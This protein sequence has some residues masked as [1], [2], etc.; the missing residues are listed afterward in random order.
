MVELIVAV[1]VFI[2]ANV[3]AIITVLAIRIRDLQK[4]VADQAIIIRNYDTYTTELQQRLLRQPPVN[5]WLTNRPN[6]LRTT[7]GDGNQLLHIFNDNVSYTI[8]ES[9]N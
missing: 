3:V 7:A 9:R 6:E 4:N 2:I 5:V 8:L 1:I